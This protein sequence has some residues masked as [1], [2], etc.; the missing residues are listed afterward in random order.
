MG[1]KPLSYDDAV[2]L[3]GGESRVVTRVEQAC[4]G[5]L[6]P[7]PPLAESAQP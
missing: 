2:K 3:L 7:S 6:G 4:W 1:R 5:R